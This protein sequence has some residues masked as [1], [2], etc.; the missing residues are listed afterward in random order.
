MLVSERKCW[1]QLAMALDKV[2][3]LATHWLHVLQH[4]KTV[5]FEDIFA[6]GRNPLH[7]CQPEIIGILYSI[8]SFSLYRVWA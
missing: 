3:P 8:I 7:L 4:N 6:T 5:S 2:L 1:I